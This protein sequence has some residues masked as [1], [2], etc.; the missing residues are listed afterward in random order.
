MNQQRAKPWSSTT[1]N[2]LTKDYAFDDP[3]FEEQLTSTG[4][5]PHVSTGG[6]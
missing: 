4:E 1:G 5:T 2:S 3:D 6:G